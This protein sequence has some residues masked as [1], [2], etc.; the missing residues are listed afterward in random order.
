[1]TLIYVMSTY[2]TKSSSANQIGLR[3]EISDTD[4]D[5]KVAEPQGPITEEVDSIKRSL[6]VQDELLGQLRYRI[7]DVCI[8]VP[9]AGSQGVEKSQVRS[10]LEDVLYSIRNM[11]AVRNDA[12][13]EMIE[14]VQL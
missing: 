6:L 13:R 3:R 7:K 8:P 2:N 10:S 9:V 4:C 5:N 12:I 1:M 11:I 14:A